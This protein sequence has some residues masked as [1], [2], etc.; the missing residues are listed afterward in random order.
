MADMTLFSP[1]KSSIRRWFEHATGSV[2][3]AKHA[4][5]GLSLV[6]EYGEMAA[7]GALLGAA[8]AELKE[9]LDPGG[10][11]IDLG[12]AA[13]GVVAPWVPGLQDLTQDARTVG[14]F[15]L[16]VYTMRRTEHYLLMKKGQMSGNFGAEPTSGD[17]IIDEAR[18]I[19]R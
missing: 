12:L 3:M 5:H 2:G 8:K 14:G 17:P 15:G 6:R 10:V 16:G 18:K 7:A 13:L 11:P 19:G 9:G 4:K 1:G